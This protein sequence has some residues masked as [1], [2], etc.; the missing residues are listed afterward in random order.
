MLRDS[1]KQTHHPLACLVFLAPLILVYEYGVLQLGGTQAESMRNGADAWIRF[2]LHYVGVKEVLVAPAG[3]LVLLAAWSWLKWDER[4]QDLFRTVFSMF[5]ESMAYGLTLW[6]ISRSFENILRAAGVTLGIQIHLSDDVLARLVIYV[7][8]GIY[9]EVI[10][11]FILLNVLFWFFR[12]IWVPKPMAW[13][14]AALASSFFFALAHHVGPYGEAN[15]RK[16][17][18][19]FRV[20]AGMFFCVV[21]WLRG[22]GITVGAHTVYDVLVGIPWEGSSS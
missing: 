3:I 4:P 21:Y 22:F 15:I 12:F 17:D 7:G 9:E 18:F 2:G 16:L 1:L 20:T 11:R 10:F 19:L 13:L 14:A 6:L 5:F 8:A